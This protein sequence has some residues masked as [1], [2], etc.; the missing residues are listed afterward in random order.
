MSGTFFGIEGLS[1]DGARKQVLINPKAV[2]ADC[3]V[4]FKLLFNWYNVPL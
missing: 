3:Q 4:G 1:R 2:Q